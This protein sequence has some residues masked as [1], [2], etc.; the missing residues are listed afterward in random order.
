MYGID[1]SVHDRGL[2][3]A[4]TGASFV[5]V[6][7]T[8]GTRFV[9]R[10]C[11]PFVQEAKRLGLMWGFYHF[12]NGLH[13]SSM[14]AQADYFVDNCLDYFGEGVPCLDWEDS[15]EKYG[16]AVVKYGPG[17]AKEWLDRVHELTGVRPMI[18][19][20]ASVASSC[21]WSEVARDYALWGAGYPNGSTYDRPGTGWYGWGAWKFPAIHQYSSAGGLDRNKAYLDGDGWARLV[22]GGKEDMTEDQAQM[23]KDVWDILHKYMGWQYKKV[24]DGDGVSDTVDMHQMQVDTWEAIPK[25]LAMEAA[26]TEAIKALAKMQGADPEAVAKAVSDAVAAKLRTIRLEVAT[27]PE[28]D[29]GKAQGDAS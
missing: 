22:A 8:D 3:L 20:N 9:D 25:L 1:V 29:A 7:A 13:K 19:M 18:Y 12:A 27:A 21:D 23:L 28:D 4:G 5:I 11:D 10:C 14:R 17:A 6:K 24:D 26:Q 16:G 2:G 15:D